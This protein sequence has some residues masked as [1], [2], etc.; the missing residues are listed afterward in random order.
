MDGAHHGADQPL[1]MAAIVGS[2]DRTMDELDAIFLSA[3]LQ[4][5]RPEFLGVI[6]VDGIREPAGRPLRI[7]AQS[8]K[9]HLCRLQGRLEYEC[10]LNLWR[11][12]ER[13]EEARDQAACD[14]DG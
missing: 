11:R 9:P 3:P 14:V 1:D 6:E 13:L 4:G 12:P 10:D 7:D 2:G 8:G 5:A